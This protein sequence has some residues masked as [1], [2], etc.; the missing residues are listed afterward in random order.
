MSDAPLL[1]SGRP[2][3]TVDGRRA[4]RLEADLIRLEARAD[5]AGVASLEAVF[6]N[7]TGRALRD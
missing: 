4:D 2:Q 1:A 7:L 5:A 3:I 6:L